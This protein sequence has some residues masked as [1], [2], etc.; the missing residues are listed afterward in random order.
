MEPKWEKYVTV[1]HYHNYGNSLCRQ[2]IKAYLKG[3]LTGSSVVVQEK[4][5]G[6]YAIMFCQTFSTFA[7]AELCF[8]L[9]NKSSRASNYEWEMSRF[10]AYNLRTGFYCL[11]LSWPDSRTLLK[12]EV[13]KVHLYGNLTEPE[14]FLL[15]VKLFLI[16][17][18]I[19]NSRGAKC[20]WEGLNIE[21]GIF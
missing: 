1:S 4:T 7:F 9:S 17:Q 6:I 15:K 20:K 21:E 12:K 5:F 18:K 2:T 16:C 10:E 11:A 3:L 13:K 19:N 14:F 8:L